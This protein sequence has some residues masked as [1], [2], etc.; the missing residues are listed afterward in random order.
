MDFPKNLHFWYHLIDSTAVNS[1]LLYK[2]VKEEKSEHVKYTLLGWRREIAF[3]LTK[4][5]VTYN[6]L[7]DVDLTRRRTSK[8]KKEKKTFTSTLCVTSTPKDVR[9]DMFGHRARF[10]DKKGRRK[11]SHCTGTTFWK[12]SKCNQYLCQTKDKQCF[13]GFHCK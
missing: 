1:W 3:C 13:E 11:I 7:V 5:G 12:C 8:S 10:Q 9:L 6:Q 4:S 2:R